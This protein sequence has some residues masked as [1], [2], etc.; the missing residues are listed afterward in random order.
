MERHPWLLR[1]VRDRLDPATATGLALTLALGLVIV[2]GMLIGALAYLVRS[3]DRLVDTDSF[4]RSVGRRQRDDWSTEAL[5]LVTE[6]GGTPFVVV[7]LRSSSRSSSTGAS[8][9]RWMPVFLV[10]VVAGE[11]IAR[12]HDQGDPRPGPPGVQ[13]DRRDARAVVSE[14][15][16][17]SGGGVLRRCCA[18]HRTQALAD[19]RVR[20]SPAGR[21]RSPS[22]LRAVAFFSACTGCRTSWPG[23]P[24][25]GPGS[26][27]AR[28]RSAAASSCSALRSSRPPRSRS[29][30]FRSP[31]DRRRPAGQTS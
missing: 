13:S 28:S 29:T 21:S 14:R 8:R 22:G 19:G 27:S 11:I 30:T 6:L 4:G 12:E 23:S 16:L 24:S 9:N 3:S 20:F 7:A 17:R 31:S 10:T 5:Q 2:G 1:L 25:G 18:H 26:P 15:S